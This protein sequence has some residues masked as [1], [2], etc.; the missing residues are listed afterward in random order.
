[1]AQVCPLSLTVLVCLR[2][3]SHALIGKLSQHVSF[4]AYS[5]CYEFLKDSEKWINSFL[6]EKHD[7]FI[8]KVLLEIPNGRG[9]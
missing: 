9:T 4:F 1:M 6:S 2:K 3:F 8:F 7:F 5:L